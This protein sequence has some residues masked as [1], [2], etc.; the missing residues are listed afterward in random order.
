MWLNIGALV[1][2]GIFLIV[3]FTLK[4]AIMAD[5]NTGIVIT[6]WA[7]NPFTSALMDFFIYRS[8]LKMHHLIGMVFLIMCA[9]FVSVSG[10]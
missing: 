8:P 5:L 7:I 2:I 1:A 10:G 4:L 6:I 9:I 3:T